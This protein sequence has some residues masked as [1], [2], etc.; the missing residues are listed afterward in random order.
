MIIGTKKISTKAIIIN[1]II[2]MGA[3]LDYLTPHI[4]DY[5][6]IIA[7]HTFALIVGALPFINIIW[8]QLQPL[9]KSLDDVPKVGDYDD[10]K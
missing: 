3:F 10:P 8:H 4:S 7:P 5:Q 6:T 9:I 1:L 2:M